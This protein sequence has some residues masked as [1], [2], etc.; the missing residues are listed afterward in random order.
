[1]NFSYPKGIKN[2]NPKNDVGNDNNDMIFIIS[3]TAFFA[4]YFFVWGILKPFDYAPDEY[5]RYPPLYH[6]FKYNRLPSG[7]LESIRNPLWGF[8]YAFYYTWL[9]SLLSAFCM[10]VV[11]IFT[12]SESVLLIAARFPCAIAGALTVFYS[13][14]TLYKL[15]P[16]KS[17]NRF[18]TILI[19][20]LPQLAFLSSYVNNDIPAVL[21]ACIICYSWVCRIKDG[22]SIKNSLYLA[23]GI[24]ITTLSY[25]N[26]YGWILLSVFLF[27]LS[28][29]IK[30]PA[31]KKDII[32][33]TLL[34]TGV[35][36]L[37]CGFFVIRNIIIYDGDLFGIKSLTLSSEMYAI[38]ELKPS[39]RNCPKN[40]GLSFLSVIANK[41]WLASTVRSS[42]AVFGYM[43]VDSPMFVYIC[44]IPVFAT[45]FVMFLIDTVSLILKKHDK[46]MDKSEKRGSLLLR[47]CLIFSAAFPVFLSAYYSYATDYQPQGRYI[48]SLLP[49]LVCFMSY[50]LNR[51]FS[52]TKMSPKASDI[53][54]SA[55]SAVFALISLYVF[56]S[57]Y[58][59][60][61]CNPGPEL[62]TVIQNI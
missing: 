45:G 43:N 44:Y 27:F 29:A 26:A 25:Y 8:S 36:F 18:I 6:V 14:K 19:G 28:F 48:F 61:D 1:M 60:S 32:I 41:R 34:I 30:K 54:L 9:P 38:D 40:L 7:W 3:L 55:L 11:G 57:V 23:I 58:I 53:V 50:G 56:F 46:A 39:M 2:K 12:S 10:K 15:S 47:I 24:S 22:L 59:P 42:I 37:F 4:V 35:V 49:A 20:F 17:I 31:K 51:L 21:G 16:N 33:H 13:S 62:T 52:I 5:T